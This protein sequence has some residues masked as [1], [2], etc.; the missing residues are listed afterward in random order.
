MPPVCDPPTPGYQAAPTVDQV[1]SVVGDALPTDAA[2]DAPAGD[3]HVGAAAYSGAAL[4]LG[5]GTAVDAAE[6]AGGSR[7]Q[8]RP[9]GYPRSLLRRVEEPPASPRTR[10]RTP[11]LQLLVVTRT[12]AL[13][14][15]EDALSLALLALVLGN[16]PAVTPSVML[17]HLCV[18]Y[19]IAEERVSVWRTRP[20]DFLVRFSHQEDLDLVFSN[21]RLEGAPFVLRWRRWSRLI[22][23]SVGAFRYRVL[24]GMKGLPSHASSAEVVQSILG[25]AG[26]KVEIPDPDALPE[27]RTPMMSVRC[28]C[29]LGARTPTLCRM[30][31]SW[32]C[33]SRRRSMTAAHRS[34]LGLTRSCTM[35]FRPSGI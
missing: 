8:D 26:A 25:S 17:Q 20:D 18:H 12:P 3:G 24:V 28:S 13:Q 23:G 21:Q 34:T 6:E 9:R 32:P 11:L 30:R 19:G 7:G 4:S 29:L 1:A 10:A 27:S 16:S 31:S 14:A 5:A 22:M 33:R 15:A 2:V 35:T